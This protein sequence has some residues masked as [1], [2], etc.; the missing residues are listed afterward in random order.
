[1]KGKRLIIPGLINKVLAH[2]TRFGTRGLCASVVRRIM[3]GLKS[4]KP[5]P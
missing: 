3:D 1:M 5:S 4:S 2:S